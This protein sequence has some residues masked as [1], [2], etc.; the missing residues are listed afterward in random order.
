MGKQL[1]ALSDSALERVAHDPR[2]SD[3]ARR[4]ANREAARRERTPNRCSDGPR[5]A[6][7]TCGM[8][9]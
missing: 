6:R 8:E 2:L 4:A 3:A 7:W 5:C 1:A 9:H